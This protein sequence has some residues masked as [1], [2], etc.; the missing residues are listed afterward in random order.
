MSNE[1][2]VAKHWEANMTSVG[3]I[4]LSV[5]VVSAFPLLEAARRHVLSVRF[6]HDL[7]RYNEADRRGLS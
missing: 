1:H 3:L 4:V 7:H 2:G 5:L 6:D